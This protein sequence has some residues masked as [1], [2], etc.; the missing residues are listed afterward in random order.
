[1]TEDWQA[2]GPPEVEEEPQRRRVWRGPWRSLVFPLLVVAAIAAVIWWLEYRPDSGSSTGASDVRYG[3][4]EMSSALLTPGMDVSPKE[5]SLAPDFL[6]ETLGGG[7]IRLS[8]LRGKAVVVNMW[9]TWCPPCRREMPQFVAAYDRYREQG[10]EIVAVNVQE[11][12]SVISPFADD[13]GV[14]FPV[15][16]DRSGEVAEEYR[17]I[18]LPT[19]YFIDRE[20]VVRDVFEGPF[21]EQLQDTPVQGAIGED[22]LSQRIGAILE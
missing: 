22:E 10:L 15:A 16:L 11:S 14:D 9:A 5:G 13:F 2:A 20:G 21:S 8:D 1:M 7:E 3:P 6:L 19:T 12:E 17:I 4:V 18:G